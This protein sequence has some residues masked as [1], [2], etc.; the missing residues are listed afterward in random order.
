M[1]AGGHAGELSNQ[2]V[3][4][5]GLQLLVGLRIVPADLLQRVKGTARLL[6]TENSRELEVGSGLL[7]TIL[8]CHSFDLALHVPL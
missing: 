7:S 3:S 5:H 1:G 6:F 8:G 2:N 4:M